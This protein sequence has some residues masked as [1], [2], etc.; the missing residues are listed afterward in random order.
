[1]ARKRKKTVR[2]RAGINKTKPKTIEKYLLNLV[3]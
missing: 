1:M 3:A 2:V